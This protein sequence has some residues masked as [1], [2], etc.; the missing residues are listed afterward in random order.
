ME[1]FLTLIKDPKVRNADKEYEMCELW[2]NHRYTV[3]HTH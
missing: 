1:K 2:K 3:F